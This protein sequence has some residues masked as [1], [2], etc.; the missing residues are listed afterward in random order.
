MKA[1][2][3]TGI[4]AM[5]CREVPEPEIQRPTDVLLRMACIG[6][7]GSDVHYYTTGRIGSQVVQYPFAVGHE[8]AAVVEAVGDAV[9]RVK[10]GDRVAVEPAM[11][12][13]NCYQ[14]NCGRPH[15]CRHLGFLGTPGQAEGCLSERIVMPE[16]SCFPVAD[17]ISM[18]RAALVEPLSIGIYAVQLAGDLNV[19]S[20]IG[21]L[22]SGTIG[23]SVLYA[24]RDA[25]LQH[26]YMTDKIDRRL[27]AARSAGASWTGNPDKTDIVNDI[28]AVEPSALDVVIECCGQQEALD[29]AIELLKPGGKLVL[30]GIPRVDRIS[31]SVDRLRR[32]EICIQNVRRQNHCVEPAIELLEHVG[33]VDPGR[34]ITHRFPFAE[35]QQAF[36]MVDRYEEG[37]IKAMITFD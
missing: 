34:M 14:C 13:G 4:R 28:L 23:L 10:P 35:T 6:V 27:E 31:F 11:S 30:V 20:R 12:C 15:T 17:S 32:R 9:T 2:V 24:A 18:E 37:V 22:G 26:F 16:T 1:F 36:D 21:I 33:D 3:L 7:C 19:D 5:E 29:Q 8:G 25:G